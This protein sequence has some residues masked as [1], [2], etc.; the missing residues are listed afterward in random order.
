MLNAMDCPLYSRAHSSP[1]KDFTESNVTSNRRRPD[2]TKKRYVV[3]ILVPAFLRPHI[4]VILVIMSNWFLCVLKRS[5]ALAPN[6]SFK[7]FGQNFRN[8]GC[9]HS[10]ICFGTSS[11]SHCAMPGSVAPFAIYGQNK[12]WCSKRGTVH[13]HIENNV[14]QLAYLNDL[15]SLLDVSCKN[16]TRKCLKS[17][18]FIMWQRVCRKNIQNP[19]HIRTRILHGG[20]IA[21]SEWKPR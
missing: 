16:T 7:N 11:Q 12:C 14:R 18:E 9:F 1:P 2:I 4:R 13:H 20:K 10:I 6:I 3:L 19:E 5:F 8:D 15:I 17:L 21:L